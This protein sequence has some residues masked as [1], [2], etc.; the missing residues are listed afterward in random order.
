MNEAKLLEGLQV[1]QL[2]G[3]LLGHFQQLVY[4]VTIS[5]SSNPM[6]NS[7]SSMFSALASRKHRSQ[8]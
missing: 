7:K 5:L 2:G 1:K 6:C 4:R 8:D 3:K